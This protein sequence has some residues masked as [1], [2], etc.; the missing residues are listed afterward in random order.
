MT[1]SNTT[2]P[3][4]VAIAV[5]PNGGRR[6]KADHKALPMAPAELAATA[7]ACLEQGASMIH[8]HVR[9]GE[10]RHLLDADAYRAVISAIRTEVGDRLVIQITSESLGIYKPE[11]QMQVVRQV[12]P[13]AVS[14]ALRELLP[15]ENREAAFGA[16]LQW[17][18]SE[19]IA[20]QIILYTPDEATKLA[21]LLARSV[22]PY[23]DIPVL[24]VLG[25]YSVGQKSAPADLL[26]FLAEGMPRFG[27]WSVCAFG[28]REAAC[29]TAGALMGG[30][31]RVGFENNLFLPDGRLARDNADLV[32]ASRTAV[33]ACGLGITDADALRRAWGIGG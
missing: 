12:K 14:L 4:P 32:A 23:D 21:D 1:T 31:V 17:L 22:L 6:T 18:K 20:P 24:Y 9:D 16:F 28:E 15:D 2:R 30:H 33:E 13:E 25:R 3:D 8:A 27:H 7:A 5:A 10:G 29:V 26:P 11:E 19:G